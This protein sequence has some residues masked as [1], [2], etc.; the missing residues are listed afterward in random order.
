MVMDVYVKFPYGPLRIKKT[1][2]IFLQVI[3]KTRTTVV[4]T[5]DPS[6]VQKSEIVDGLVIWS[7]MSV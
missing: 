4:A 7:Q 6:R 1:L 5:G 2:G 3:T